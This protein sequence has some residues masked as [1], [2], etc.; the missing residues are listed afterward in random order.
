KVGLLAIVWPGRSILQWLALLLFGVMPAFSII[1]RWD[2]YLSASLYSGNTI[3]GRIAVTQEGY[4][5]LPPQIRKWMVESSP[6]RFELD[7]FS[8][9]MDELNVPEYPA[10]RVYRK[11]AASIAARMNPA[12]LQLVI[13]HQPHWLTGRRETTVIQGDQLGK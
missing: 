4:L 3:D 13:Q 2:A 8:W 12:D 10:E 11:I 5:S 7:S 1:E 6:G 9:A